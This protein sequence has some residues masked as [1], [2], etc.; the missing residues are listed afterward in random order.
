MFAM[1]KD[2]LPSTDVDICLEARFTAPTIVN[3]IVAKGYML[4]VYDVVEEDAPTSQI[5]GREDDF[6]GDS[7]QVGRLCTH[8]INNDIR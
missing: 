6:D 3:L 4:Q 1:Y 7:S 8:W 2:V 5:S